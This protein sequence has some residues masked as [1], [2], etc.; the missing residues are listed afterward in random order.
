MLRMLRDGVLLGF[1][2]AIAD[3]S[4]ADITMKVL[5]RCCYYTA[6]IFFSDGMCPVN[7]NFTKF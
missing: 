7:F 3:A 1:L 2:A 5:A 4:G 6:T